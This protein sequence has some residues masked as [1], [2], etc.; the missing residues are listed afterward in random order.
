[1]GG[2]R[3]NHLYHCYASAAFGMEADELKNMIRHLHRNGIE[4]I[5]DV[6]FNHTAEGNEH[7]KYISFRH[8]EWSRG[9][10]I[11]HGMILSTYPVNV[12]EA[13]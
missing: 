4:V 6:V 11:S 13:S 9:L 5:L 1:M 3:M 12:P 7:G 2:I 8:Y 10:I